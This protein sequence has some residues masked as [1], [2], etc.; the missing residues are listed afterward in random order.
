MSN[1]MKVAL[2]TGIREID[3]IEREIPCPKDDEVLVKVE[4]IGICGSD[5]HYYETG[6]IG[7][8]KVEPP[9]V[10]G[11][12]VAGIVAGCGKGV[13]N[14]KIGDKVALEPGKTCGQCYFCRNG[15]Y[16]LC[17]DVVFFATPPV[18]G[19]FQEYVVHPE[20]LSFKLPSSMSTLEGAMIEPLSVGMHAARQGDAHVGQNVFVI[21]S[22]CI[23]LS[24]MLAA[25]ACGASKVYLIDIVRSRLDK[26]LELG[27]N[28]II[29]SGKEDVIKRVFELTN[30]SGSDLIIDTSGI[31]SAINQ[32]IAFARTGSTIVLVG[33]PA[34]GKA[35]LDLSI[36]LNK[37]I[38]FKTVFRYRHQYP[39]CI[40]AVESGVINIKNMVTNIFDFNN[41]KEAMDK[42]LEDKI[43]IVK[44]AIKI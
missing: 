27:A 20:H 39:L 38:T 35:N 12:E 5:L 37:E 1:K 14:L 29:N 33:Y 15:L 30:G 26:A 42:S 25:K 23:G 41:V 7:D 17:K 21:G 9:F 13:K 3:M 18:D 36:A 22:G 19:V 16:N 40:S 24:S 43:N 8:F 34:S 6:A 2:M 31:E 11:H 44:A 32:S 10:L 4:Y 28:G